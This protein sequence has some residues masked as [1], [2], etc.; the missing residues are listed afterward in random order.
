MKLA[1]LQQRKNDIVFRIAHGDAYQARKPIQMKAYHA[2]LREMILTLNHFIKRHPGNKEM[3][4]AYLMRA[5]ALRELGDRTAASADYLFIE[6]NFPNAP[7]I[8]DAY[9]ELAELAEEANDWNGQIRYLLNIEKGK[10]DPEHYGY[11]L[12]KLAWAHFQI[13]KI[14]R[15]FAYIRMHTS[16][17]NSMMRK[18]TEER[19]STANKTMRDELLADSATF[20]LKGYQLRLST[21]QIPAALNFFERLVNGPQ[22]EEVM[23]TVLIRF[24]NLLRS[25]NLGAELAAWKTSVIKSYAKRPEALKVLLIALEDQMNKVQIAAMLDSVREMVAL[26]KAYGKLYSFESGEKMLLESASRVQHLIGKDAQNAESVHNLTFALEVIYKGYLNLAQGNGPSVV[27]AHYNLAEALS[28]QDKL[29]EAALHYKWIFKNG[30]PAGQGKAKVEPLDAGLKAVAIGYDSL[31]SQ[32]AIPKEIRPRQ[33]EPEAAQRPE[34]RRDYVQWRDFLDEVEASHKE[35]V[36]HPKIEFFRFEANRA[37][38]ASGHIRD[39]T[40]RMKDFIRRNPAGQ[41]AVPSAKLVLD[42]LIAGKDWAA[43]ETLAIEF[44]KLQGWKDP[45]FPRELYVLAADSAYKIAENKFASK[46]YQGTIDEGKDFLVKF[47][48]SVRKED[49]LVLVG[50]AAIEL[51][52]DRLASEYLSTIIDEMPKSKYFH[53]AL[54]LRAQLAER[55]LD[56]S[57]AARDFRRYLTLPNEVRNMS[58][59]EAQEIRKKILLL[60]W[61]SGDMKELHATLADKS[62]CDGKLEETCEAYQ[63]YSVLVQQDGGATGKRPRSKEKPGS[64]LSETEVLW[65]LVELRGEKK[66][67]HEQRLEKVEFLAKGWSKVDP[68]LRFTLVTKVHDAVVGAFR[69]ARIATR[70]RTKIRAD[71]K[72]IA[73]RVAMI[74]GIEASATKVI[75]LPFARAQVGILNEVASL[76]TDLADDIRTI[77]APLGLNDAERQEYRST[78]ESVAAPF[79]ETAKNTRKRA[80]ELASKSGVENEVFQSVAEL[81]FA[82]NPEVGKTLLPSGEYPTGG[83]IQ[84][85]LV[86]ELDSDGGYRGPA[87]D[88]DPSKRLK[89]EWLRALQGRNWQRVSYYLQDAQ[90]KNLVKPGVLS[91]MRAVSLAQIGSRAEAIVELE[92]SLGKL[93]PSQQELVKAALLRLYISTLSKD[94]TLALIQSLGE[95]K[96]NSAMES[97][98]RALVA[99]W[100]APQAVAGEAKE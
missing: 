32:G 71:Q 72:S 49:V 43:T 76:Y 13:G 8:S 22:T 73:K 16:F 55:R 7:E 17:Q 29:P 61:L 87:D 54:L 99:S 3:P 26:Y 81:Y 56:F 88:S 62:I 51:N 14:D 100:R 60:A 96:A 15:A 69:D 23:S 98:E 35:K 39:A 27:L 58:Q 53:K 80:F 63:A 70:E 5:K 45:G 2:G 40:E 48:A 83:L 66:L 47:N 57:A 34:L 52:N 33:L 74:Q 1:V 21:Y 42:S 41:Y 64:R 75:K 46:D 89:T 11:A 97:S 82:E 37:L 19:P 18:G 90:D 20:F 68:L 93:E 44:L 50:Q 77:E 9:I 10:K 65:T 79:A 94:K 25:E 4:T 28:V 24:S 78:M 84:V 92:D 30:K 12:Y 36:P 59:R 31:K 67:R 38:Y 86:E 85:S 6:R 95:S 91:A